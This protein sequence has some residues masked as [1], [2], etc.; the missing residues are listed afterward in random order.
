MTAIMFPWVVS[1]TAEELCPRMAFFVPSSSCLSDFCPDFALH[2]IAVL[3]STPLWCAYHL[4]GV[5]CVVIHFAAA[6]AAA[7]A[8]ARGAEIMY[9]P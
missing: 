4:L 6:A 3:S 2:N 7:A 1:I 8:H 9:R 5:V